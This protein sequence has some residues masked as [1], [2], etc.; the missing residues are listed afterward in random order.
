VGHDE[1]FASVAADLGRA[2]AARDRGLVYGGGHVGLMG[3]VA[4]AALAAGGEVVGVMTADLV[5]AEVAHTGLTHLEIV[6]SMHERKARMSELSDAVVVLPGGFGTLDETFEVLTWNQLGLLSA[7][8]VLLDVA[9][10][11][12]SLLEFLDGAVGHGFVRP[13][14]RALV[15]RATSVPEALEAVDRATPAVTP[16]WDRRG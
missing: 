8:V 1:R 16:K 4:D 14:H 10:Y 13:A 11:F 12:G 6:D 5:R 3:V 2:L 9:G 15:V 7:P